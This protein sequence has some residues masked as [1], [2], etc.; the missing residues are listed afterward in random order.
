M[1][2]ETASLLWCDERG[3]GVRN[4][5]WCGVDDGEGGGGNDLVSKRC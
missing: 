4:R 2:S 5:E 1:N 3:G